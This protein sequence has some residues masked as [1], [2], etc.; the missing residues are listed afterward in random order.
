M[1][2]LVERARIAAQQLVGFLN[3]E[4]AGGSNPSEPA[5]TF[6]QVARHYIAIK[7]PDWGPHAEATA[8]CV[9]RKHLIGK[10]GP[11]PVKELTAAEIQLLIN[12]LVRNDASQPLLRKAVLHLRAILEL[13]QEMEIILRNPMR[14]PAAKIEYKSRKKKSERRLSC[15][16][17]RALLSEFSGRDH[18]IVRMFIQLG[19]RPEELFALRRNDVKHDFIRI[20]EVFTK[21]QIRKT[22]PGETEVHVYVPPGLMLELRAWMTSNSGSDGDWLFPNV[23]PRGDAGRFPIG[24][25]GFRNRIL[26]PAAERAG[27]PGVDLLTLRRTCATHFG[28]K[29]CVTDTQAQMRLAN[30]STLFKYAPQ[31]LPE[32][33][34][35]AAV[36]IEAEIFNN[37]EPPPSHYLPED[38]FS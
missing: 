5:V 9:I 3:P 1:K 34:K 10:L 2:V 30:P 23:R 8:K 21:G 4:E 24:Q 38:V 15:E 37:G 35:Q 29:A 7:G 31:H 32:S 17:C 22:Q 36:A 14:S 11:R 25:N 16:E 12:G 26:Q 28:Q 18:L 6:E 19:L 13:A 33:L 27:I 20:D